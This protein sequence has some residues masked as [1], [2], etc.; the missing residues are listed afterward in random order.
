MTTTLETVEACKRVLLARRVPMLWGHPG[1]AK[2]SVAKLLA[3]MLN[4][5]LIDIR[6]STFDPMFLN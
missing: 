3:D 2:S 1:M 4:L 6:L 5:V